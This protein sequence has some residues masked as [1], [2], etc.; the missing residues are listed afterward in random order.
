MGRLTTDD[1]YNLDWDIITL[2]PDRY[3]SDDLSWAEEALRTVGKQM[4]P[5]QALRRLGLSMIKERRSVMRGRANK[6]LAD[7]GV[8]KSWP[9]VWSNWTGAY[10]IKVGTQHVCLR[11]VTFED[12]EKY[13]IEQR[14][15]AAVRFAAS[16]LACD[17]AQWAAE[18]LQANEWLTIPN[19]PVPVRSG[20]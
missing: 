9:D 4:T 3:E 13:E 2:Q 16:N 5:A 17:G 8:H 7:L 11:A 12:L 18:E 6:I 19:L 10:P 15:L 1:N 14:R 20:E